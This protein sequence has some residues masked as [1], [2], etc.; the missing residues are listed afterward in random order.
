MAFLTKFA[1]LPAQAGLAAT[2][3]TIVGS[4][5]SSFAEPAYAVQKM[6]VISPSL[7]TGVAAGVHIDFRLVRAGSSLGNL[8]TL[9][10]VSG[11]NLAAEVEVN[12]P[13]VG[14]L[15]PQDGDVIDVQCVQLATGLALP[16]GVVATIEL[17]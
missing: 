14:T 7:V 17:A 12:I 8:G 2:T 11:T 15:I 1:V 16:A 5:P 4:V 9:S 3:T 10:L 13:A 6:S